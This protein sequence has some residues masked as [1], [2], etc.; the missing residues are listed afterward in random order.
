MLR[1]TL[2]STIKFGFRFSLGFSHWPTLNL[3]TMVNLPELNLDFKEMKIQLKLKM[4]III[5]VDY[6]GLM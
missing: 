5:T 3:K 6:P 1:L 2:K 4:A